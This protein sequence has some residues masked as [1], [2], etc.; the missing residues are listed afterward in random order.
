M[1]F[2]IFFYHHCDDVRSAGGGADVKEHR[3]A[4]RRQKDAEQQLH[5]RLVGQRL[6]QRSHR[7]KQLEHHRERNRHIE[8]LKPKLFAQ[9]NQAHHHQG[10]VDD[11]D[12]GSV[13]QVGK[14]MGQHNRKS[15]Y[16]AGRKI[17]WK[18]KKIA[19]DCCQKSPQV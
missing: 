7:L 2:K 6:G 14:I 3:R 19:A 16:A 5:E 4:P 1:A 18:L 9:Q 11:R 13:A 8:G 17:V 10:D 15:G 12:D